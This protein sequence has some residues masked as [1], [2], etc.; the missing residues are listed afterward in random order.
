MT[1]HHGESPDPGGKAWSLPASKHGKKQPPPTATGQESEKSKKKDTAE[2]EIK[3]H[4]IQH[5]QKE[6]SVVTRVNFTI[7]PTKGTTKLSIT[8]SMHRM[9]AAIKTGD[10]TAK[11][12]ATD[13]K[14]NKWHFEGKAK[15]PNDPA[16][17]QAISSRYIQGLRMTKRNTLIGMITV[18]SNIEVKT[19]I[20]SSC[21]TNL[22]SN[23]KP[24]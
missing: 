2:V 5:A 23:Q 6:E 3:T 18:R 9:I 15:L 1:N 4:R 16:I 19:I 7:L 20:T 12:I 8:N 11:M 14:G 10:P 13:E 22:T 24:S 21:E 17:T